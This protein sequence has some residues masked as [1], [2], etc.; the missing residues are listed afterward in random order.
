MASDPGLDFVRAIAAKIQLF[1]SW[2]LRVDRD[3][4]NE[5]GRIFIQWLYDAPCSIEGHQQ[6]WRGRKW[7]MSPHMT[8]GEIVKS[9]LFGAL[10]AMEHEV[11]ENFHYEGVPLFNP[12]IDIRAMMSN[13]EEYASRANP[14]SEQVLT[15]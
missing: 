7:Y 13:A 11:R 1:P 14:G 5:G 10:V 2:V 8:E 15:T 6:Q 12:H 4:K 3:Q 9:A